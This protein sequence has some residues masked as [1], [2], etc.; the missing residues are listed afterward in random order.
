MP[1]QNGCMILSVLSPLKRFLWCWTNL[2]CL[3]RNVLNEH[4]AAAATLQEQQCLLLYYSF[5]VQ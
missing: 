1:S 4:T 2:I 3:R 5:S